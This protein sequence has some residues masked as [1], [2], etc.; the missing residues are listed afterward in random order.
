[1]HHFIYPKQDAFISNKSSEIDYNFGLDEMLVVGV[2][3]SY[4]KIVNP[5]KIYSY[6]NEYVAG[7]SVEDFTGKFTGS[8]HL[9]SSVVN[10]TI[11]GGT[12]VFFTDY[13][14]GSL[15]ASVSGFETGSSLINSNFSGSLT[16]FTGSINAHFING[17]TTGSIISNC[18]STFTGTLTDATGSLTGYVNGNE[19]K[20]EQNVS[21]VN[22]K[23]IN[24]SLLKFDLSFISQSIVSGDIINPKF[25]LK[26]FITEAK[27]LPIQ[28]KI[29]AFPISQSW[30]QGDG[31]WSD[32]GSREGVSWNCRDEY[33]SS[34]WF[35]PYRTDIITSSVDYLN[36]YSY[37]S[38]SF[39]RGGGTWYNMPCTQSFNYES[40]DLNLDVTNIVNRW[41]DQ[42]I[43]NEGLILMCSE[44]TNPSGSNAH[45]FF[46]SKE[47][48]TIYSPHLDVAWDDQVFITG[49]FGTGSVTIQS[50]PSGLTGSMTSSI[51]ITDITAS[52]SF[53]GNAYLITDS[54][55]VINSGSSVLF[56]G[57]SET[58]KGLTID[59]FI[60]GTSSVEINDIKYIT[61][62]FYTG[63]FTNCEIF[64]EVNQSSIKGWLSGSFNEKFFLN[65]SIS[66]SI[67][68]NNQQVY[69]LTQ[70]S[71]A[72]G[73]M[74]GY[75][76]S[77]TDSGGV[78]NGTII[79]G[80]LKG[81]NVN[82]PFT[83]SFSYLTSSYLFTSSVIITGSSFT[84]LNT[85]KPFTIVVQN[86]KKEYDFGDIPRI[87]VFAREKIPLKNFEK[88]LQQTVYLNTKL[89]PSSS[90]YAVKDNETERFIV[91]FDNY[92]KVSCD[93]EGH[94][95]DLNT[96]ALEKERTYR[97]L[98]K[99][100]C[101]DGNSY[102]FDNNSTFKIK[103]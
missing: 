4:S 84:T 8:A 48:N 32:D 43:P 93:L 76:S 99:V 56:T 17:I 9:Y 45:L 69:I 53:S 5:T 100:D 12:N 101:L 25:F 91:D 79:D 61:A 85:E 40:A 88:S 41:L 14:S 62:S 21:I 66:G 77:S 18:F 95:F 36:D 97:V 7:M 82:I 27:E 47:T 80:L 73:R 39:M 52:G 64:G 31:Y 42:T 87:N 78:F 3:Q 22:K 58:I 34:F 74:I 10:G 83:G 26:M 38:E 65:R 81:A 37:V 54:F 72:P 60:T 23:F 98:I 20:N 63:D 50:Y 68:A 13:F 51:T 44:E 35:F 67:P 19:V 71:S 49:S 2:S 59:G 92:T 89:L 1:M 16:G 94:Y 28:Y 96:S 33:S 11:I 75:I 55:G 24:R 15:S 90:Y 46:F 103:R 57:L 6:T 102:T 86:L 29:F 70:N 30:I